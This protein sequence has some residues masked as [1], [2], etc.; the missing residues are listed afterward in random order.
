M[1]GLPSFACPP[2]LPANSA[3]LSQLPGAGILPFARRELRKAERRREQGKPAAA[4]AAATMEGLE[5]EAGSGSGNYH[6]ALTDDERLALDALAKE[7]ED[8][9]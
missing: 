5:E 3:A 4:A 6:K 2:H 1:A 7:V 8:H 9:K